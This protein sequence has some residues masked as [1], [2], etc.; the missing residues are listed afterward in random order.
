MKP[1]CFLVL[2][3][4]APTLASAD[5]LVRHCDTPTAL[6]CAVAPIWVKPASAIN[7]Q[8]ARTGAPFV[9]LGD[10]Q[11]SERIA[12]CY[13]DPAIQPGSSAKCT[14]TVPNRS[15]LWE[16]KST[17]Y[18]PDQPLGQI[19]LTWDAVTVDSKGEPFD[20]TTG[21]VVSRQQD[22][23][24]PDMTDPRCGTMPWISE[25]V[26]PVTS[27]LFAGITG[28]WCFRVQGRTAAGDLGVISVPDADDCATAG[29]V[30]RLPGPV[31]N[32]KAT[33]P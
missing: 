10:I 7:V 9:K 4:L 17:I 2:V 13:N 16:L 28:R 6:G 22:V 19:T 11:P 24:G 27:K 29:Q 23:C 33:A 31:P 1:I 12:T 30:I 21:Y 26:G 14:T 25:D 5:I 15:D 18:P 3:L 32:I 8:V 20:G